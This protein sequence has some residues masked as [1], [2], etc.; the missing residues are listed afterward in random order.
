MVAK[1]DRVGPKIFGPTDSIKSSSK[2]KP[3]LLAQL[4]NGPTPNK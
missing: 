2:K 3:R 1:I 4:E